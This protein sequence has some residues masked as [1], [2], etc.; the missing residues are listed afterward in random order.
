MYR[1]YIT[2]FMSSRF[3]SCGTV[4][5]NIKAFRSSLEELHKVKEDV[6]STPT[7]ESDRRLKVK[8]C[9]LK[10]GTFK[11]LRFMMDTLDSLHS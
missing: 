9:E 10:V 8:T 6:D 4:F 3:T 11:G 7:W 1:I 2:I 5:Y